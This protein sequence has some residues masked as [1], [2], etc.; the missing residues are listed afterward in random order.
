VMGGVGATGAVSL[1]LPGELLPAALDEEE[2]T[3]CWVQCHAR[4]RQGLAEPSS[5]HSQHWVR[6]LRYALSRVP[7]PSA[8]F[9]VAGFIATRLRALLEA[10]SA[11]QSSP[12]GGQAASAASASASGASASGAASPSA[13]GPTATG[14]GP[15]ATSVIQSTSQWMQFAT[16]VVHVFSAHPVFHPALRA[17]ADGVTA[18]LISSLGHP[19]LQCRS[20]VA[21]LL[22]VFVAALWTPAERAGGAPA[23]SAAAWF[24]PHVEEMQ[25]LTARTA[26]EERLLQEQR[27]REREGILLPPTGTGARVTDPPSS[28]ELRPSTGTGVDGG[29]G[30][31]AV[32]SPA[33][34][35]F[36]AARAHSG[37]GGGAALMG[38][39]PPPE[40]DSAPGAGG[41]DEEAAALRRRRETTV[42]FLTCAARSL[43]SCMYGH[44]LPALAPVALRHYRDPNPEMA[45]AA[46]TSVRTLEQAFRM[47][48]VDPSRM[49]ASHPLPGW[50]T[51][52]DKATRSSSWRVRLAALEVIECWRS[53]HLWLLDA[54]PSTAG[55][56]GTGGT[57]EGV[58]ASMLLMRATLARLNDA[59]LEVQERACQTLVGMVNAE[60]RVAEAALEHAMPL[61]SSRLPRRPKADDPTTVRQR[62]NKS[63]RKRHAG[64][65]ALSAVLL[66]HPYDVP[67]IVSRAIV[68]LAP[69]VSDPSPICRTVQ[70][71]VSDFKRT[72]SDAW[73]DHKLRLSREAVEALDDMLISPH[74]YA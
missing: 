62:F 32:A 56:G 33:G 14:G 38:A 21:A 11:P 39:T 6:G 10:V 40:E 67:P 9:P 25:R 23:F 8:T 20:W 41:V 73:H 37:S 43:E 24:A 54:V 46:K 52:L 58:S 18:H 4:L 13:A 69:H 19:Y 68:A 36:V 59:H 51:L 5:V 29:T 31:D 42:M 3:W 49:S 44:L 48:V 1:L 65:L 63:L 72:H 47:S 50:V 16:Q 57:G 17:I 22:A 34:S 66:G 26:E 12:V 53:H 7:H 55:A 27:Q 71:V 30:A 60:P 45:S 64:V 15:L 74:Y 2:L 28:P 70:R 35:G 61:A